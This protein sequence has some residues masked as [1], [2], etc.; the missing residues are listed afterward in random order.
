MVKVVLVH[1]FGEAHLT[2]FLDAPLITSLLVQPAVQMQLRL[3]GISNLIL[4]IIFTVRD[5][6]NIF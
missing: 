3:Y 6:F 2:P 5:G 4:I 1:I